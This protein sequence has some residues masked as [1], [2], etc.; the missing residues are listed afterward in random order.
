MS[1]AGGLVLVAVLAAAVFAGRAAAA[2]TDLAVSSNWAGYAATGTNATTGDPISYS[3][4]AG[5]WTIPTATCKQGAETW[6]AVWIGL[7]GFTATS[8]ALEQIGTETDC[9]GDGTASYSVWREIVPDA[10]VPVGLKVGPGDRVSAVVVVHGTRVIMRLRNLTR[11]T[12]YTHKEQAPA[13]DLTSAD[14]IVEAP[15]QCDGPGQC[16][17]LPLTNFGTVSF[18]G[19]AAVGDGHAG[20]VA[21]G[22]WTATPI[23][24]LSDDLLSPTTLGTGAVPTE[25][26]ADG[27]SFSV[28]Y[29]T[30]VEAPPGR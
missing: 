22:A 18:T 9:N 21:D 28:S 3:V 11:H 2:G 13:V 4:V 15:S 17:V 25:I 27:G 7:G 1:R 26:G 10:A 12:V 29:S 8:A 19:A 14:W 24:L 16:Q 20:T 23:E 30:N 5:S 6:S